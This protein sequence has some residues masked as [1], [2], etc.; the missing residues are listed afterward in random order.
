MC[1]DSIFFL[2]L[3]SKTLLLLGQPEQFRRFCARE[4]HFS[5]RNEGFLSMMLGKGAGQM[6]VITSAVS[7]YVDIEMLG[8][9]L[10]PLVENRFGNDE[11]CS[12]LIRLSAKQKVLKLLFS[13]GN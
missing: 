8:Y 11:F 4:Q 7:A 3:Y 5:L 12:I 10:F 2:L 1:S 9:F 6:V 13:V